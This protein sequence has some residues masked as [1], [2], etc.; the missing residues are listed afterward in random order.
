MIVFVYINCCNIIQYNILCISYTFLWYFLFLLNQLTMH[1][2][3]NSMLGRGA[4]SPARNPTLY[5]LAYSQSPLR[6]GRTMS[7]W[8]RPVICQATW[9]TCFVWVTWACLALLCQVAFKCT[10]IG[11]SDECDKF[12]FVSHPLLSKNFGEDQN[13]V[14]PNWRAW[15]EMTSRGSNELLHEQQ[16]LR[17]HKGFAQ[18]VIAHGVF[19]HSRAIDVTKD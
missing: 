5:Y 9:I 15:F 11:P 3:N 1:H 2:P 6:Q 18:L 7:Q 10:S 19:S 17:Q 12:C 16:M 4:G 13:W 14:T 8:P